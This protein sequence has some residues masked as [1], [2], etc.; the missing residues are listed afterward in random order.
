MA[1]EYKFTAWNIEWLDDLIRDLNS[2]DKTPSQIQRLSQRLEGIYQVIKQISP[3]V[4][5]I[6]EGPKS[7]A[8]IDRFVAG[9]PGY[10]AIKRSNGDS[11]HQQG[12]Q[13]IW[14]IA[15]E[16]IASGASLLPIRVWQEYTKMASPAGEH[17]DRWPVY[18]WGKATSDFHSHYRHPQVLVLTINGVRLE[19]IGGHFKSKLTREGNFFSEDPEVRLKYI[20]ATLVNRVKLATE[21]QNL[22]YYID[23]RFRQEPSPA[24]MVMG[25]LNDGP[26]KEV[27]ERQFL[28]FD[29]LNNVQG[30]VFEA[31]KFLN[32]ALFDY[33]DNLRWTASFKDKIDPSRD[34]HIL[35]DHIMFSQPLVNGSLP[36][37]VKAHAGKVEHEVYDRTSALMDRNLRISDHKPLSC[38]VS[39]A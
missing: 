5:C 26:G 15:K 39:E 25:D 33:P 37:R 29:L 1:Q 18:W 4:L 23:Q 22:R 14:F 30:D 9:L 19:L 16:A 32:H 10:T 17:A 35:L 27:F 24:I 20:E 21:A 11:Y 34:P 2:P 38:I 36:L 7:E 12:R 8:G 31:A 13:W 28:F 3:D 6:T